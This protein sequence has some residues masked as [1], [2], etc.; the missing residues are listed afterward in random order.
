MSEKETQEVGL[1][2]TAPGGLLVLLGPSLLD[3]EAHPEK[4]VFHVPIASS[5]VSHLRD[6]AYVMYA[7]MPR[8]LQEGKIK[9]SATPI[10]SR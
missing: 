6:F 3:K 5:Q 7:Q 10:A 8:L 9:V 1:Q 4:H 2:V